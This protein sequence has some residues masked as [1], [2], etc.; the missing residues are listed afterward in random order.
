MW[1]HPANPAAAH[2]RFWNRLLWDCRRTGIPRSPGG[3]R[4]A[5]K[6]L[7]A[8][9]VFLQADYLGFRWFERFSLIALLCLIIEFERGVQI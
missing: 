4:P 3:L 8:A 5:L 7:S 6:S 2:S 9:A 1:S